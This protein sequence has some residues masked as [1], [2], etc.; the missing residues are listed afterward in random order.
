MTRYL[1]RSRRMLHTHTKGQF[2]FVSVPIVT[3]GSKASQV[4]VG[5]RLHLR[6]SNSTLSDIGGQRK[7]NILVATMMGLH[8]CLLPTEI[9][10]FR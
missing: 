2:G 9:Y 5:T 3:T 7:R 6:V 10:L 8:T 4:P 1:S